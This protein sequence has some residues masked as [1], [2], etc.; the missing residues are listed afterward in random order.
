MISPRVFRRRIKSVQN[1]AK[2]TKAMEMIATAKMRRSQEQA[3]SGRPYA[4]KIKQVIADLAASQ[5][6]DSKQGGSL[7]PLLEQREVKKIGIIYISTDRGLCGGLNANMNRMVGN[8][9]LE[10][11]SKGL[12]V[13]LV[14]VG[15]KGRDFM[16]RNGR[17]VRAEFTGIDDR[18][19]LLAT[20]PISRIVIDD[21]TNK[22]SDII[23]LA[24]PRFVSMM[25]QQPTIEQLIPVK[26]AVMSKSESSEYIY[27]PNP[28]TVLAELLPRFVRMEVYHSILEAIASEHAARMVAMR[29]ATDNAKDLIIDLTISLNKARQEMITKELLDITGGANAL[30]N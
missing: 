18:P 25:V 21:Y 11:V 9:I 4:E 22:Y 24:Y 20:L 13:S 6:I 29:N 27:E 16:V 10:S 14:A 1:T 3:L 12:S 7:H 2:I 26:P 8:F 23:Y 17:D 15:R 30:T 28:K 19:D 5:I